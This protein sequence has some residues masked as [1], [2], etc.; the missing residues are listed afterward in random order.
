[1]APRRI[2]TRLAKFRRRPRLEAPVVAASTFF[3]LRSP[4]PKRALHHG[5]APVAGQPARTAPVAGQF[6]PAHVPAAL[7]HGASWWRPCCADVG[8]ARASMPFASSCTP[9]STPPAPRCRPHAPVRAATS[10]RRRHGTKASPVLVAPGLAY[11]EVAGAGRSSPRAGWPGQG[12]SSPEN[13]HG[14]EQC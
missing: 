11:T 4:P 5:A 14:A 1:M 8:R 13:L 2:G 6:A 3:H 9:S 12:W 10:V 7:H